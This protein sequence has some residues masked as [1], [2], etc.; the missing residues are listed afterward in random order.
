MSRTSERPK[1]SKT[2]L[3]IVINHNDDNLTLTLTNKQT[4][5]DSTS[6]CCSGLLWT[7]LPGAFV[8]RSCMDS[9][10]QG[11]SGPLRGT[12]ESARATNGPWKM[13]SVTA[14]GAARPR[15]GSPRSTRT[16]SWGAK[17]QLSWPM[18][19]C[20][21]RSGWKSRQIS[22][23]RRLKELFR[24]HFEAIWGF[25]GLRGV[26]RKAVLKLETGPESLSSRS[27][28]FS[29]SRMAAIAAPAPD[30][31]TRT[32]FIAR[33]LYYRYYAAICRN[34]CK[35]HVIDIHNISDS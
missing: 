24:G 5:Y 30:T 18:E 2:P 1:P 6:N 12:G 31:C 23:L 7:A 11:S 26:Y 4:Q 10:Q 21:T 16:S 25:Q 15:R 32:A 27:G 8:H 14:C 20:S 13:A 28:T 22:S 9:C 3:L 34:R 29:T 19:M 35:C 33:L 17:V